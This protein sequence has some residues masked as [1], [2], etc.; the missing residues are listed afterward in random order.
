M[1]ALYILL[2]LLAVLAL[3]LFVP[4]S[5]RL[6]FETEEGFTGEARYLFFRFAFPVE[7]EKP[8]PSGKKS[9]EKDVSKEKTNQIQ[10]IIK[11][12]GFSGFLEFIRE[13]G[14]I[15]SGAAKKVFSHLTIRK[16]KLSV[17]VALEDAAETAIAYGVVCGMVYPAVSALLAVVRYKDYD[18]TVTPDFDRDEPEA[19]MSLHATIR[20]FFV[21]YAAL[22]ALLRYIKLKMREK[23]QKSSAL[24]QK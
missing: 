12:K 19:T 4:I 15:A 5:I 24:P 9:K 7:E 3:L 18:V 6:R 20:L 14:S 8:T 21:V 13:L 2:G 22:M 17:V 1:I 11:E 23:K 16:L 10:D